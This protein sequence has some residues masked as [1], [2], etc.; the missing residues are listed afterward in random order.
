VSFMLQQYMCVFHWTRVYTHIYMH[1]TYFSIRNCIRMLAY[2]QTSV[3][4]S[5]A[6]IIK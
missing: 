3:S 6:V 4:Y 2:M 1:T 5:E